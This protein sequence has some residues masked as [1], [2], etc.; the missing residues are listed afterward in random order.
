MIQHLPND[1]VMLMSFVNTKLRDE[2]VSR[3]DLCAAMDV[4]EKDIT[5]ILA[6]AG[7]AY[8]EKQNRFR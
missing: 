6:G 4:K 7:Y 2:Y 8:D 3:Q 5:D 1:P